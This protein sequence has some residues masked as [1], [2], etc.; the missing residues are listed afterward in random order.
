MNISER[1]ELFKKLIKHYENA[2]ATAP[3]TKWMYFFEEKNLQYGIC[4]CARWS[5]NEFIDYKDFIKRITKKLGYSKT[6]WFPV[7]LPNYSREK[8][9]QLLQARVKVMKA[10]VN[11]KG[12]TKEKFGW[13][14]E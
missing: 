7:I 14:S 9:I 10:I 6:H 1:N 12:I 3:E 13:V 11:K 4:N 2:I 5:F 8:C